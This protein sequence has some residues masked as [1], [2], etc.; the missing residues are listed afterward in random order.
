[1]YFIPVVV[2]LSPSNNHTPETEGNVDYSKVE[3][4]SLSKG[5]MTFLNTFVISSVRP[6]FLHYI[7]TIVPYTLTSVVG[8]RM[9]DEVT[10]PNIISCM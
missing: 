8:V 2:L 10:N 5:Q 1:M 3:D 9:R 4:W 6:S 7:R